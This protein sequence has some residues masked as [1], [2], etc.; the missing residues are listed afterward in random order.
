MIWSNKNESKF[1][2][3]NHTVCDPPP[4]ATESQLSQQITTSKIS[5][6]PSFLWTKKRKKEGM[7][8][9]YFTGKAE[10]IPQLVRHTYLYLMSMEGTKSFCSLLANLE[11]VIPG[12]GKTYWFKLINY[13]RW[14]QGNHRQHVLE[15]F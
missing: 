10:K 4:A 12:P 11:H 15:N 8:E 9:N 5:K 13:S 6:C 1:K 14:I 2:N 7:M 3:I